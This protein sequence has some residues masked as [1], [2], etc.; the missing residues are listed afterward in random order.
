MV[1]PETGGMSVSPDDPMRLPA[2]RRPPAMGGTGKDPVFCISEECLGQSLRYRPDPQRPNEHGFIEPS[3]PMTLD[4][5]QKALADTVR[6]WKST[7]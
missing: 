1:R 5:F 6:S 7:E 4:E 2:F 3:K